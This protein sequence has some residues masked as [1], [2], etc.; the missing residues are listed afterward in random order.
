MVWP[1]SMAVCR[2]IVP[3]IGNIADPVSMEWHVPPGWKVVTPWTTNALSLQVPSYYGIVNNYFVAFEQG[4]VFSQRVRHLDLNVVWLGS[5]DI[6]DYPAAAISIRNVVNAALTF[7]GEDT[8]KEAITLILRD[9][10]AQNR[11]RASTEANSIEF[12]FKKGMTFSRV[13]RDHKDGFF[14]TLGP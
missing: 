4:S 11:F 10:N 13:W 8:S 9:S 14:A 12:N 3:L 5:D 2:F 6:N 1:F 7:F